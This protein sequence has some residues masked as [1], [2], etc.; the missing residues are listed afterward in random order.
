M[1]S[2]VPSMMAVVS[3]H[4]VC[5]TCR[6]LEVRWF[7]L[8]RK[9]Y[10]CNCVA[11]CVTLVHDSISGDIGTFE[12]MRTG[13]VASSVLLAMWPQTRRLPLNMAF[14]EGLITIWIQVQECVAS[15]VSVLCPCMIALLCR[16]VWMAAAQ[17]LFSFWSDCV[18]IVRWA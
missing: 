16:L 9:R 11:V 5:C 7:V 8:S 18:R 6:W 12:R 4:C 1:Y 13:Q 17:A 15:S 10:A 14:E 3:Y 2:Q